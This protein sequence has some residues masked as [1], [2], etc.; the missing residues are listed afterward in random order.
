MTKLFRKKSKGLYKGV[1]FG[2]AV[3]MCASFVPVNAFSALADTIDN[4][5]NLHVI[6]VETSPEKTVMKGGKYTVAIAKYKTAGKTYVVGEKNT[7]SD[8]NF[9]KS[10][11]T[12][13]YKNTSDTEVIDTNVYNESQG[14]YGQFTPSRTGTYIIS[15]AVTDAAGAEYTYD[16][17][18]ECE[19]SD[20]TFKFN[21]FD[22][23]V[24]PTVYDLGLLEGRG[25][26]TDIVLPLPDVYDENNE[27]ATDD[28]EKLSYYIDTYDT[29]NKLTSAG[30]NAINAGKQN[31]VT[32]QV[33][34]GTTSGIK[35]DENEGKY[36]IDGDLIK[37][38][39]G[40]GNYTVTYSYYQT[41]QFITSTTKT[42]EVKN[43]HYTNK[44]DKA[45][46][47][48]NASF[49]TTPFTSAVTGV[50]K[51]LPVVE[52]TTSA[53][54]KPA[55]ES[56]PVSYT[57]KI[58]HKVENNYVDVTN[59][60]E[61][62]KAC[63]V[64]EDDKYF[65]VP[66]A[67]G[68]YKITYTVTDFYGHVAK[69]ETT[70]FFVTGVKDQQL[71]T[72]YAYDANPDYDFDVEG[73]YI[74]AREKL[75][76][77]TGSKNIVIYAIGATDNAAKLEDIRL[78]R[79]I[80][81]AGS[82]VR[83]E[84]S[85]YNGYNLI[86]NYSNAQEFQTN[87][88]AVRRDMLKDGV[89]LSDDAAIEAWLLKNNY[90]KVTNDYKDLVD[91]TTITDTNDANFNLQAIKDELLAKGY[92]YIDYDY[93]FTSQTYR[94]VYEARDAYAVEKGDRAQV[95]YEM[96]VKTASDSE[97]NSAPTI[98]GPRDL[99]NAYLPTDKITFTE[100]SANDSE[101]NYMQIVKSYR[102]LNSSKNVIEAAGS[103]A[104][105]FEPKS[106]TD[107]DKLWKP[108]NSSTGWFNLALEEGK[109]NY[110][111]DLSKITNSKLD[112][113]VADAHYV[114]LLIYTIDDHGNIG[115]WSKV[116]TIAQSND[117][118]VPNIYKVV[119]P[120]TTSGIKKTFKQGDTIN[121]P[122]VYIE[123]DYVDY[124]SAQVLVYN[125]KD[126]KRTLLSS[127]D[128]S[129]YA[130]SYREIF[131]VNA[132]S[133]V[134]SYDGDYQVAIIAKDA[135]NHSVATFF[136]YTVASNAV[137]E[138]PIISN[139]TSETIS[140]EVGEQRYL[141]SPT[142][143]IA[144]SED[145]GYI[146]FDA[147]DSAKT[148][149]YYSV[150]ALTAES[151]NFTLDKYYF[152][153]LSK[154]KYTIQ[155]N[156]YLIQ[157]ETSALN[158]T[159]TLENGKLKTTDGKYIYVDM[160]TLDAKGNPTLAVNSKLNGTG[161]VGT[162]PAGVKLYTLTSPEQIINVKDTGKPVINVDLS[163]INPSYTEL[164][165]VITIP[166][167]SATDVS[168]EGINTSKSYVSISIS[169]ASGTTTVISADMDKWE[170]SSYYNNLVKDELAIKLESNG[171]YTIR[172]Y[173]VDY[174]NNSSELTKI[175]A[176]GDNTKP[177][178]EVQDGFLNKKADEYALN[179]TLILNTSKLI[180][181]D[182]GGTEAKE[183]WKTIDIKLENTDTKT[184]IKNNGEVKPSEDIYSYSFDLKTAGNYTLTI[185]VKDEAGWTT[186]E[187]INITVASASTNPVATY[188]VVGTVLIV[189]SVLILAGVIVYFVYSKVKNDKE[190][191]KRK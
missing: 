75:K 96:R 28:G 56:V 80:R 17:E 179:D 187:T 125:I 36:F 50:K 76:S 173:V 183:L 137:I 103:S 102:F 127:S 143:A 70:S 105:D 41:R 184:E 153:A 6:T 166:R 108:A 158:S 122:T 106:I 67:D 116:M 5:D 4:T 25:E 140:L 77:T 23:G 2:L 171:T 92:A 19:V 8:A 10:S 58:E 89:D 154:G 98:T 81:D 177:T 129:P 142:I 14:V 78:T 160:E 15:Y 33:S 131:V 110:T 9:A 43:K 168:A 57:I 46:Y 107:T 22:E 68:D 55:S 88:F 27:I 18:I 32:I 16:Y 157:Y 151:S 136:E 134:A 159:I 48:L 34:G 82:T 152:R 169:R 95:I 60:T 31:Y 74:S 7:T 100:P 59:A 123:D 115:T 161:A 86:F 47:T 12:V 149:S 138:D 93:T 90:R 167:I 42:F 182:V 135:A 132:G 191:K 176:N 29:D 163:H 155:Y 65:F 119:D 118:K 189:V 83:I 44:D 39:T 54:D 174:S 85:E 112:S 117:V 164:G 148:A 141:P 13:T 87:N 99:Q 120:N 178:I 180:L 170:E 30:E 190:N 79:I 147:N 162:V 62:R 97:D 49:K 72:V 124:M 172:Y 61:D 144:D 94:V 21:A 104:L 133:F 188:Q 73:N 84:T 35:I 139:I 26:Y 63:L 69:T 101:D 128:M 24:I 1:V 185:T 175:I 186:T 45:D 111:I 52:G 20:A 109:S 121:L 150:K 113:Y 114:E 145:Y 66:Y 91:S 64:L 40:A 165:S 3:L 53:T 156:V 11:V 71:P 181:E 38:T 146:G 37:N 130:D 126:G 51:E